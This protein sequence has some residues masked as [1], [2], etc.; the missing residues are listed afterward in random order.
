M[1]PIPSTTTTA[2]GYGSRLALRLAGTTSGEV[3]AP[4]DLILPDGQ[5][6]KFLSSPL[7]KN[8][9]VFVRPKSLHIFGYPASSEGRFAIVTDM[10]RDAV[11]ADALLTNSA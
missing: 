10:R 1:W 11:D 4:F 9:L 6:T 8:I 2:G 7:C 3:D 5:I